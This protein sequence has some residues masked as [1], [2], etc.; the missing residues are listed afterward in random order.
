MKSDSYLVSGLILSLFMTGC[1]YKK[2]H[3]ALLAPQESEI[4]KK[5]KLYANKVHNSLDSAIVTIA[6]QLFK[7]NT[8]QSKITSIILTSFA[9]LNKLNKTTTFGRLL[10]ESMFNELHVRKFHVTDFR[11]QDA[12]SVND[13][14]EFHITRDVEKLKDHISAT[15]YILVGTYVKFENDS[16]LI[17]A[18]I[19]DSENGS[20]ISTARVVYKPEDCTL[21]NICYKNGQSKKESMEETDFGIDIIKDDCIGDDCAP[22]KCKDGICDNTTNIY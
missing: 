3:K 21:F 4:D 14:G 22:A 13:Q 7:S 17:N 18:R 11:G 9:D 6:D 19:I 8:D 2:D 20:I 16:V 1:S 10:S 5:E 12:V 15:E